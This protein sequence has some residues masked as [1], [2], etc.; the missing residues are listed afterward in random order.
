M[1][2]G[3]F[4]GTVPF[5]DEVNVKALPCP[6]SM[7]DRL[8]V[9]RLCPPSVCLSCIARKCASRGKRKSNLRF[10][11]SSRPYLLTRALRTKSPSCLQK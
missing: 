1:D 10:C 5:G 7:S 3:E 6:A 4:L 8:S 9:R 11:D 2:D